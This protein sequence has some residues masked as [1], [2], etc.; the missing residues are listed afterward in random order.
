MYENGFGKPSDTTPVH[1]N[2]SRGGSLMRDAGDGCLVGCNWTKLGGG[3]KERNMKSSSSKLYIFGVNEGYQ[4]PFF[5]EV[6]TI[7]GEEMMSGCVAG[8][9]E[10]GSSTGQGKEQEQATGKNCVL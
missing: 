7:L 9:G 10:N 8:G 3:G 6:E 2:K 1:E 5:G 4:D